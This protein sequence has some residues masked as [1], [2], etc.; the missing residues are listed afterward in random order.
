MVN[1]IASQLFLSL[2]LIFV[3]FISTTINDRA[4]A[5][6]NDSSVPELNVTQ[7]M[8]D[9]L[10]FDTLEVQDHSNSSESSTNDPISNIKVDEE[11]TTEFP[12]KEVMIKQTHS[13]LLEDKSLPESEFMYVYDSSPYLISEAYFTAKFPC[14]DQNF[15]DLSIM[16]GKMPDFDRIEIELVPEFSNPGDLCI[17]QGNISNFSTPISEIGIFNNSTEEIEFAPATS[18]VMSIAERKSSE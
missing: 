15:T 14:N 1:N 12:T 2:V 4:L 18:L 5:Q 16:V 7:D 11:N 17:Y 3:V 8:I 9:L 6:T 13:V 10:S